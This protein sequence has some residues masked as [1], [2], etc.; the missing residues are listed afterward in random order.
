MSQLCTQKQS[1]HRC[2]AL[3]F[4]T[5]VFILLWLYVGFTEVVPT[6]DWEGVGGSVCVGGWGE[7][8]REL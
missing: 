8:R 4:P 5:R 3:D 6:T 1:S 7:E 2:F